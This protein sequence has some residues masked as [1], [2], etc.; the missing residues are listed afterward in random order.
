MLSAPTAGLWIAI[1]VVLFAV[2]G[3]SILLLLALLGSDFDRGNALF[4]LAVAG[5]LAFC[6]QTAILDAIIWPHFFR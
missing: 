4:W 1:R 2:G 5:S 3:A 6:F